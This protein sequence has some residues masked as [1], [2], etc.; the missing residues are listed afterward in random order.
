[1]KRIRARFGVHLPSRVR[2]YDVSIDSVTFFRMPVSTTEPS[3]LRSIDSAP[4]SVFLSVL[5]V[6]RGT[7]L[8]SSDD[9][10]DLVAGLACCGRERQQP[11]G[12]VGARGR[13]LVPHLAL[14]RAS[15]I[16]RPEAAM[17]PLY[18]GLLPLLAEEVKLG[19]TEAMLC[20]LSR[21]ER[22]AML[23]HVVFGLPG[24][25]AAEVLEAGLRS[26]PDEVELVL[27]LAAV[28]E[29]LQDRAAAIRLLEEL[30]SG[31]EDPTALTMLGTLREFVDHLGLYQG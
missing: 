5:K 3:S 12:E 11:D 14:Y 30:T 7:A 25:E 16:G 2:G 29:G 8:N 10:H 27:T 9:D 4:S 13:H 20:A 23:V 24:K 19:C 26:N 17:R 21:E 28:R 1:M 18:R 6:K 31:I 22:L 15:A